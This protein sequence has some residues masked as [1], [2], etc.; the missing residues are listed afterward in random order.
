MGRPRC[1]VKEI[2]IIC[3]KE[4]IIKPSQ[5]KRIITCSRECKII[6]MKNRSIENVPIG[7]KTLDKLGYVV[8]KVLNT[9]TRKRKW[10]WVREHRLIMEKHLG[11][12][13]NPR[14]IVHHLNKIQADNR[15]ENLIVISQGQHNII[16]Q[17]GHRDYK[18]WKTMKRNSKGQFLKK[19][20]CITWRY[21]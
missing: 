21:E 2:C 5:Y 16:H 17:T 4:F 8:V 7:S 6:N 14:E 19:N 11:R 10:L 3:G 20:S 15:V 12:T 9:G 1:E 13:L 18:Q